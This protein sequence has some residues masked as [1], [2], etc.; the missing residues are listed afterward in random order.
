MRQVADEFRKYLIEVETNL[1]AFTDARVESKYYHGAGL[2]SVALFLSSRFR[3]VYIPSTQSYFA[4][5]PMGS[6]PLPDPLWSTEETEIVHDG[7]E[8]TRVDKVI[9][10]VR[11]PIDSATRIPRT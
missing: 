2:A 10:I 5:S 4:L 1:R 7:C 9:R 3:K 6:H 8:A 11:R